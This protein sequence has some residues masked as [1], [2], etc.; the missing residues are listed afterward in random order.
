MLSVSRNNAKLSNRCIMDNPRS[1]FRQM[2]SSS[3]PK[4]NKTAEINLFC[5]EDN[6]K[7]CF[8]PRINRANPSLLNYCD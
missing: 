5:E 8:T 2:G 4:K 6:A 7:I 1:Q 3:L